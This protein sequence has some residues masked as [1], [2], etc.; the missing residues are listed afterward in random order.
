LNN[1]VKHSGAREAQVTLLAT[2]GVLLLSVGDTGR[3][4]DE[5]GG[6]MQNGL[7]LA[8]MRERLRL[9]DGEFSIHSMPGQG[10]TIVAR[11]PVPWAADNKIADSLRGAYAH[12]R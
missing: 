3:G 6:V 2:G 4:F 12:T 5:K 8:S 7:G 11:V 1:V 9:I 10:T